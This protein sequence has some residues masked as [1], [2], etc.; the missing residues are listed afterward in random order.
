MNTRREKETLEQLVREHENWRQACINLIAAENVMSTEV[1][2]FLYSDLAQRYGDYV[3][4][5]LRARKYFGN[6]FL[7]EIEQLV[8]NLAGELFGASCVETRPLSGH[9]AGSA[10]IMGLTQPGDTV[11]ELGREGGGHRLAEKLTTSLLVRLDVQF[12]PFDPT[13][14]NIDI[15][16]TIT[17]IRESRPRLIILGSSN[18]LFPH[19]VQQIAEVIQE[20]GDIVL[21]YDASHVFG[22]IAGKRFQ[23]PLREGAHIVFGSTHKTFPGP[24]G[25]MILSNSA[26]LIERV[27]EMVYPGLV[28]N[29]HIARSPSLGM[30]LLEMITWGESYAA[31]T[32]SNAQ[33]LAREIHR[34][35]VKVVGAQLGYTASHTILLQTSPFGTAR[36]V[37]SLLEEA[38][39]IANP[40]GLPEE[41]GSEGVRLGVQ[42]ITRRGA[43]E[44]DMP[45]LA[46]LITDVVMQKKKP[47]EVRPRS[48]RYAERFKGLHFS[49]DSPSLKGS[50]YGSD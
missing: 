19:P 35:G 43:K 8:N 13:T 44:E 14:Y 22:L 23:D 34:R 12:L 29:H 42:E 1:K 6:Q 30:A 38:G 4:R 18:F 41:L 17:L 21:A 50:Y 2:Q 15:T 7:I 5:D 10:V 40:T 27:S 3:G 39:I 25:G 47:E 36:E 24:Q 28:T 11:L 32:I 16:R 37:G 33:S 26:P 49:W 31:Q 9:V 48:K 46:E 20:M 45:D